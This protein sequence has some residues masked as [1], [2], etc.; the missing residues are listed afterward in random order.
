[1]KQ[2]DIIL[3]AIVVFVSGIVSIVASSIFISSPKNRHVK[4]EIIDPI[5]SDFKQL[6][7]RYFNAQSINPTQNIHIGDNPNPQ[8]FNG[9][10]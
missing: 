5:S 9:A 1:M 6:D 8:P 7:S 3:I 4:V 10:N 2:K